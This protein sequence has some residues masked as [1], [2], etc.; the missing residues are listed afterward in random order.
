MAIFD[1][2]IVIAMISRGPSMTIVESQLEAIAASPGPSMAIFDGQIVV[3]MSL[4]GPSMA[5]DENQFRV[6]AASFG[7]WY[8]NP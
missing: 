3:M 5:L 4:W 8:G 1:G 6:I 2:Q 7:T